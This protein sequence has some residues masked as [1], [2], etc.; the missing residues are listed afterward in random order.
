V[1]IL[2]A[3]APVVVAVLRSADPRRNRMVGSVAAGLLVIVLGIGIYELAP[4]RGFHEDWG[5]DTK[6]QV[7]SAVSVIT[8]GCPRGQELDPKAQAIPGEFFAPQ[9][10]VEVLQQVLRDGALPA[11]IGIEPLPQIRDSMCRSAKGG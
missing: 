5:R 6:A 4:V 8:D 3:L 9:I 2:I 11:S 10:T 7:A 1:F